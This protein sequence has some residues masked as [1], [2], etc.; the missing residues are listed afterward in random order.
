M[1]CLVRRHAL[2][3]VTFQSSKVVLGCLI[4]ATPAI[5]ASMVEP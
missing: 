1:Y 5:T 3:E 2:S 4:V